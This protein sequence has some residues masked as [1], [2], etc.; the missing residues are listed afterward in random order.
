MVICMN[1]YV[2]ICMYAYM[3]V[4]IYE[5]IPFYLL[6]GQLFFLDAPVLPRASEVL[7]RPLLALKDPKVLGCYSRVQASHGATIQP[8]FGPW[9]CFLEAFLEVL[10]V[11][12]R[13]WILDAPVCLEDLAFLG[14]TKDSEVLLKVVLP[15]EFEATPGS[16]E[17]RWTTSL[18]LLKRCKTVFDVHPF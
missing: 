16:T 12:V 6:F 18:M 2:Y 10:E 13:Q 9:N 15:L 7:W 3:Y 11:F 4:C 14:Q 1:V 17:G 5:C 8:D